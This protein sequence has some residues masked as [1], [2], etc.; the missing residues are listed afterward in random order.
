MATSNRNVR[1]HSGLKKDSLPV[2]QNLRA[3]IIIDDSDNTSNEI[4]REDI[5]R[6]KRNLNLDNFIRKLSMPDVVVDGDAAASLEINLE[7][8]RWS[9]PTLTCP[10]P[11]LKHVFE[12]V[13]ISGLFFIIFE[14]SIQLTETNFFWWKF[15]D[16]WIRTAEAT[17]LPTEPQPLPY[18]PVF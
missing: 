11:C 9:S 6:E 12:K 8:D 16:D 1:P 4:T 13:A 18:K 14:F 5:E 17:D 7:G 10:L 2:P 15:A 3:N